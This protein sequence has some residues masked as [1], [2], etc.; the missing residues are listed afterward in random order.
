MVMVNENEVDTRNMFHLHGRAEFGAQFVG[1]SGFT[2]ELGLALL[3]Y[4]DSMGNRVQSAWP[5]F[6]FGWVW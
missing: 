2:T 4:R 6:H 5:I 3:V 1:E